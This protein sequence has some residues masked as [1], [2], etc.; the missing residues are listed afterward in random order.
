MKILVTGGA[1]YLGSVLVPDLLAR[2]HDVRVVD[3]GYF[4]LASLLNL[5][6]PVDIVQADL[7]NIMTDREFRRTLLSDRECV[8][9]LAAISNDDSAAAQPKLTEEINFG[10]TVVLAKAA[11]DQGI[12]FIFSSSCSV[13]GRGDGYLSE[14]ETVNPLTWYAASKANSERKLFEM[15]TRD[16]RPIVLRSGTLFGRSP[17]MR[18]DLVVNLF[19]RDSALRGEICIVGSGEQ[20]RP[21]LSVGDCARAFVHFAESDAARHACYNLCAENLRVCDVASIFARLNPAI[22]IRRVESIDQDRRDYKVDTLRMYSAGLLPLFDVE[23]G[24]EEMAKAL[25]S[26]L[27][28]EPDSDIYQNARWARMLANSADRHEHRV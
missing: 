3:I 21:Y 16:W 20:W 6:A 25:G 17:R 19:A 24:A 26:G 9:H 22:R 5:N 4:G 7:R 11:R 28:P 2:G 12:R 1:G 10:A 23:S 27:I 18:F 13:Y 8:I 14:E 15:A